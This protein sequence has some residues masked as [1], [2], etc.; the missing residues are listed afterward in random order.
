[1]TSG[2]RFQVEGE[3]EEVEVVVVVVVVVVVGAV[4]WDGG[5]G[6]GGANNIIRCPQGSGGTKY[7][8][9]VRRSLGKSV[10]L[11][12]RFRL[13]LGKVVSLSLC[14]PFLLESTDPILPIRNP[15]SF[16]IDWL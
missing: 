15:L 4:V 9:I 12:Q 6:G 3:E 7:R 13:V 10:C 2:G 1:M 5:G 14:P 8:R 16:E 11:Q